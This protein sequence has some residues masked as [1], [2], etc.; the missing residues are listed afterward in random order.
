MI[1]VLCAAVAAAAGCSN[2][3]AGGSGDTLTIAATTTAKPAMAQ[4]IEA[5]EKANPGVKVTANYADTDALISTLRTQLSSGTAPDVF[6]V[7]PGYGNA[8]GVR[9]LQSKGYLADLSGHGF[10]PQM[11]DGLKRTTLIDGKAY[12]LPLSVVGIGAIYNEQAVAA[13]GATVPKTFTEVLQFCDKAKAA[14]KVAFALGNQTPWVTQ[15]VNYA[16]VATLVF[17]QNP[18]FD[19]EMTAGKQKFVGSGWET[20]FA[21]YLEMNKRGCFS[22]DPLGTSFENSVG[23]VATGKAL[24]VVQVTS[25]I[26]GVRK[27]APAG[28]TFKLFALPADDDA[29]HTWMPS[30]LGDSYAVNAKAKNSALAAKFIDF[31]ASPQVAATYATTAGTL[32]A[33]PNDIYKADDALQTLVEFQKAGRT[34]ST[35]GL[36]PNPKVQ[37][38]HLDGVQ[39]VFAGKA[40]INEVLA[41]MDAAYA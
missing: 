23:Q 29:E 27:Q 40:T 28:T 38:T 9:N 2:A 21:K 22:R 11:P 24:A 15:L 1:G 31:L 39:K 17:Q 25:T 33:L 12:A 19:V 34:C 13:A 7:W 3:S 41:G 6:F 26:A 35:S 16:L 18:D 14:G 4:A 10:V 37:Q 8:A 5:F 36:W 30:I 20:A 32:P